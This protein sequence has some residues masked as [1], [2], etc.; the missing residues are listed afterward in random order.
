M[1]KQE[2][3]SL[4]REEIKKTLKEGSMSNDSMESIIASMFTSMGLEVT[5]VDA[6]L[7]GVS[8]P[9]VDVYFAKNFDSNNKYRIV[10][11]FNDMRE[12]NV[13]EVIGI[14][15]LGPKQVKLFFGK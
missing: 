14:N 8:Q 7:S 9:S 12:Q 4:I 3:R 5:R 13:P 2:L 11:D 15:V 6:N 1:N 10:D